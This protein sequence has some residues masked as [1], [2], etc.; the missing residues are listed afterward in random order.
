MMRQKHYIE[1]I[2]ERFELTNERDIQTPMQPGIIL[3]Q[4]ITL[5]EKDKACMENIPYMNMVGALQ[6]AADC[7]RLDILFATSMIA[8]FLTNPG[9][10]HYNAVKHCFK[11]LKTTKEKWLVLGGTNQTKLIGFTDSDGMVQE[12]NH[13]ILGYAFFL[14]DSLVS[15]SS[16]RQMLV[17][18]S[19]YEAELIA[20]AHAMQEAI[21][22][23]HLSEEIL[24]I[25]NKPIVL[26]CDNKAVIKIV[27][28]EEIKYSE[29]TKHLDLR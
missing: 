12:G 14:G 7:T 28:D 16:K 13:V 23:T 21:V 11:Y 4:T 9:I 22:L 26:Y 24:Q 20:L 5:S 6:Y 3:K 10:E 2:C 18:A 1:N 15:W 19:T 25:E 29:C 17:A 8:R 27:T